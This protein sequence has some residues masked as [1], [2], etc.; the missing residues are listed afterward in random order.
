MLVLTTVVLTMVES[1]LH[2]TAVVQLS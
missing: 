1:I 2:T